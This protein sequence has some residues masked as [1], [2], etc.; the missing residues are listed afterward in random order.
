MLVRSHIVRGVP[1]RLVGQ[2]LSLAISLGTTYLTLRYLG[3]SDAGLLYAGLAALALA[4]A[5]SEFG[6]GSSAVRDYVNTA[7][8]EKASM[9][10]QLCAIRLLL[11]AP[12]GVVAITVSAMLHTDETFVL[13]LLFGSFWMALMAI[14]SIATVPLQ[15]EFR[16]GTLAAFQLGQAVCACT[17]T[18]LLILFEASV[19]FFFL[20]QVPGLLLTLV[21]IR[22]RR[23]RG[24]VPLPRL[25][26]YMLARFDRQLLMLGAATVLG[27][28]F[29]R[30]EPLAV[31][32]LASKE[33]AGIYGA[34][35][36][37]MDIAE[38]VAPL[39]LA[40]ILPVLSDPSGGNEVFSRR[41]RDVMLVMA[42]FGAV[43]TA[44]LYVLGPAIMTALAGEEFAG[45][46]RALQVMAVGL[47]A[48]YLGQTFGYCLLARRAHREML[49]GAACAFAVTA[50]LL[51]VTVPPFGAVGGSCA[52]V[53]GQFVLTLAYGFSLRRHLRGPVH[54]DVVLRGGVVALLATLLG[55][56]MPAAGIWQ[57]LATAL[58]AAV[59]LVAVRMVDIAML[60]RILTRRVRDGEHQKRA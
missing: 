60:R 44:M 21:A 58:F 5:F 55:S 27:V 15:S 13:G 23:G 48:A 42:I 50:L 57:G 49:V 16:I 43:S 8:P 4:A 1:I 35:F 56:L 30:M 7:Q 3:P 24:S 37:V 41:L 29:Y 22:A 26:R 9:L 17:S 59:S 39:M 52:L 25:S 28:A 40:I 36:R 20:V 19:E 14:Y 38:S 6:L 31:Q 45:S 18:A 47:Y 54:A 32:I 53:G 11:L 51:A 10:A 12:A 46:G 33:Q 34:S 2:A